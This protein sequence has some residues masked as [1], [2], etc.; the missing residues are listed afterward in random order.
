M[1]SKVEKKIQDLQGQ[2]VL[3]INKLLK[4]LS[5]DVAP[6]L[7]SGGTSQPR[8]QRGILDE[9]KR[10]VVTGY[11]K[12]GSRSTTG[13]FDF[14]DKIFDRLDPD[15]KDKSSDIPVTMPPWYKKF[16]GPTLLILGGLAAFVTGIMT[17]G[18]LKGFL[19]LLSQGGIMGGLKWM[20]NI[21]NNTVTKAIEALSKVFGKEAVA[22]VIGSGRQLIAK[23]LLP[24]KRF[25]ISTIP[26]FIGKLVGPVAKVVGS[27]PAE[28]TKLLAKV[29]VSIAKNLKFIPVIG[30]LISFGFAISRYRKGDVI[31]GTIDLISGVLGMVPIGPWSFLTIPLSMGLSVLNAV[32]DA[33]AGGATGKQTKAKGDMLKKWGA[34]LL[35]H[36]ARIPPMSTVYHI[37]QGITQGLS[38]NWK[39]AANH[40]MYSIPVVGTV[41]DWFNIGGFKDPKG[42]PIKGSPTKFW[43][44]IIDFITKIPPI[45]TVFS[46]GKM[47]S[48]VF[49][50]QWSQA[51]RYAMYSV[52]TVGFVLDW[53]NV[54]SSWGQP[55]GE[56]VEGDKQ[57]FWSSIW[58]FVTKLPPISNVIHL[59]KGIS[60]IFKGNFV[61]AGKH[62]MRSIPIIGNLISWF[63]GDVDAPEDSEQL[64]SGKGFFC[65]Y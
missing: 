59:A 20:S 16:I 21:L 55:K 1:P 15:K 4:V 13:P 32:L 46:L 45:Q 36:M 35:G 50:G 51:A 43:T 25:F 60:N 56:K 18:P 49:Q 2:N 17:D 12:P 22:K 33:K 52:P 30:G 38:G 39:A 37:A 29:G 54:G 48:A 5:N 8:N 41:L 65:I 63:G 31:G 14:F 27:S 9:V 57:G 23:I 24:F 61:T 62:M 19:K 6:A 26:K 11:A 64:G 42:E 44:K 58:N 34:K 47:L 3:L 10:T 28:V 7:A 53:F 40:F